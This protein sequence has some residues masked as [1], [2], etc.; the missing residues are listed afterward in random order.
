MNFLDSYESEK[1]LDLSE[2]R[3]SPSP[4]AEASRPKYQITAPEGEIYFEF[5][6]TNNE[7]CAEIAA[8]QLA[9]SL[10]IPVAKTRL[11]KYKENIG[12]A[13]YDVG[14]YEEPD[15]SLSY[16]IK[17]FLEIDGFI[18]MCLFDYLV[19]NE[20]RHAGN[21]GISDKK[22]APLFDHNQCFGGDAANYGYFDA[23]HFML[24]VS[25]AF[26]VETESQH[27]H[28][29]ILKYLL[30]FKPCEVKLFTDKLDK[31]PELKNSLLEELYGEDFKRIERLYKKRVDYMKKKVGEFGER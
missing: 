25:S 6:L 14:I 10:S 1:I 11:S 16:S 13:S 4:G 18:Q 31:P 3:R 7:I 12:I 28:D 17:D 23:E 24:V 8:F 15:D 29:D 2:Y 21:W 30:K 22:V 19:M 20:D 27:R 9:E 26:Y 5:Q